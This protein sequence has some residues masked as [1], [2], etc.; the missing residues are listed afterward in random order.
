MFNLLTA[1]RLAFSLTCDPNEKG[2]ENLLIE[3]YLFSSFHCCNDLNDDNFFVHFKSSK[4]FLFILT[5]IF[6]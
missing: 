5:W 2:K 3:S 6:G 4:R 1:L